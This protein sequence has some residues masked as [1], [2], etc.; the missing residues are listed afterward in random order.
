MV[1]IALLRDLGLDDTTANQ[2]LQ[3]QFAEQFDGKEIADILNN[4]GVTFSNGSILKGKIVS[5][6]GD[7]VVVEIGLKID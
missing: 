2:E 3:T 5:I 7:D 6:H 4:S 1:N